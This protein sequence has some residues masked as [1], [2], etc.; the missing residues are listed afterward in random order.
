MATATEEKPSGTAVTVPRD[1]G[2]DKSQKQDQSEK[3]RADKE[4]KDRLEIEGPS[5]LRVN[6]PQSESERLIAEGIEIAIVA[7]APLPGEGPANEYGFSA[8]FPVPRGKSIDDRLVTQKNEREEKEKKQGEDGRKEKQEERE[9]RA[10]EGDKGQDQNKSQPKE[11][12]K[13]AK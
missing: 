3:E 8:G 2:E 4:L 11:Q 9:K 13:Q 7:T 5:P 10:K 1:P 6:P 12:P